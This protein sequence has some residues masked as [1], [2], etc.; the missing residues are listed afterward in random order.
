MSVKAA[1]IFVNNSINA[2]STECTNQGAYQNRL[3]HMINSLIIRKKNRQAVESL[4][5]GVDM[6]NEMMV[7]TK[8]NILSTRLLLC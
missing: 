5:R 4:I 3:E 2:V 7:F 6:A 8:N 1:I